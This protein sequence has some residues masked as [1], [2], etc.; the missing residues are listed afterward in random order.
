M[1]ATPH[2]VAWGAEGGG[3]GVVTDVAPN[4]FKDR[5]RCVAII[6]INTDT[7]VNPPP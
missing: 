1:L 4:S 5:P 2:D 6:M 3:S 7:I